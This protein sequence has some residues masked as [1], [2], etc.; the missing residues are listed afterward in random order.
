MN[1]C[2][3][4]SRLLGGAAAGHGCDVER[5]GLP[6]EL[7]DHRILSPRQ[8]A[9]LLGLSEATLERMRQANE[10]PPVRRL[11]ARRLGYPVRG[12]L[13]WFDERAA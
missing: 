11:S 9:Q 4:K 10:G 8:A 13:A 5:V 2:K 1:V 12:L 3:L 6:A 7:A